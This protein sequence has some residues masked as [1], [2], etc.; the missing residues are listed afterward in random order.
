MQK[1][2]LVGID[3]PK[4]RDS[5]FLERICIQMLQQTQGRVFPKWERLM[6]GIKRD[7]LERWN[8]TMRGDE[9]WQ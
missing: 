9:V 8:D 6:Q 2:E 1:N 5:K 3:Q 4:G 7:C